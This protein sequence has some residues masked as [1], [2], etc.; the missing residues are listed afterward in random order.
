MYVEKVAGASPDRWVRFA[1]GGVRD[2]AVEGGGLCGTGK[3]PT[4]KSCGLVHAGD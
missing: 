2:I 3:G 1:R 4:C